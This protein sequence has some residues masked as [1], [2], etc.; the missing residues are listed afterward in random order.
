MYTTWLLMYF[1]IDFQPSTSYKRPTSKQ[2]AD[3][4]IFEFVFPFLFLGIAIFVIK[5][6]QLRH[7]ERILT[8][9][10]IFSYRL[11]IAQRGYTSS[12]TDEMQISELASITIERTF[13]GQIF[14]YGTLCFISK[15]NER[16]RFRHVPDVRQVKRLYKEYFAELGQG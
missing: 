1:G 15:K 4:K 5:F 6:L 12:Q 11:T 16:V 9:Q 8:N 3:A 7:C 13:F 2:K 10:R 14:N